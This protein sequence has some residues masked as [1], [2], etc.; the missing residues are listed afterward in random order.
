MKAMPPNSPSNEM[1]SEPKQPHPWLLKHYE[2]KRQRTI[3]L[4]KASV[5]QLLAEKRTVTI[6]AICQKSVELDSEGRGVKKSSIFKNP[7]AHAYYREHSDSYQAAQVRKRHR[8]GK[9]KVTPPPAT[10]LHIDPNRDVEWVRYRYLQM[11]KADLVERLLSVEQAYAEV[12][13]QL[14]HLQ[15]Q[16][17]E[18]EEKEQ[19]Q[20]QPHSKQK[21]GTPSNRD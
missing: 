15:F 7:A 16:L 3:N 20:A 19:R 14:V 21:G 9:N 18:Q 13:Q 4:V 2:E 6:E 8:T 12:H 10:S 1:N 17:L 11:S 5:N